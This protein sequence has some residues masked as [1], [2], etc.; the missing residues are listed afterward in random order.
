[1]RQ[2][3]CL[4]FLFLCTGCISLPHK[5]KAA[6]W[7]LKW[8]DE[9]EQAG[10]PDPAKWGFSGRK[11]PNWACY[12]ADTLAVTFVEEG[13]L[14]LR[15]I[16]NRDKTD[17]ARYKTACIQT[18]D[19][20]YFKYGKIEVKAK[21]PQGKGSWPAIW[22]MP[23]DSK[24]GGWPASGEIDIMEHLNYDPYIYQ[25]LHSQYIDKLN[26][27]TNPVHS[28][29]PVFKEGAFNIY[30]LEWYPDR[31]D[32]FVNG[33]KTFT[34]PKIANAD[35]QQWPFDQEYYIILNQALGGNWVGAIDDNDLPV[36]MTVDWVRVYQKE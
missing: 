13:Q 15:G 12:C 17:T 3:I 14:Y 4:F 26:Q 36:Q 31:L 6:G 19:K 27:K 29:T 33:I 5:E 1:M 16:L 9:F 34:Y 22:L 28:A 35:H 25:T 8:E 23:Q 10:V 21:I 18:K 11:S 32:F 7:V 30:G 20:F 24:Y 2:R